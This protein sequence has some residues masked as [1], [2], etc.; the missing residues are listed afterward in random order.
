MGAELFPH[1]FA[2]V[3]RDMF[4]KVPRIVLVPCWLHVGHFGYVCLSMFDKCCIKSSLSAHECAK[5]LQRTAN[6]IPSARIFELWGRRH[7][8]KPTDNFNKNESNFTRM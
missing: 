5:H 6:Q 8:A 4:L 2:P 1:L 3:P 7:E